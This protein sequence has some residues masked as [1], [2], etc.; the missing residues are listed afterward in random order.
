MNPVS[1]AKASEPRGTIPLMET[2]RAGER[3][4]HLASR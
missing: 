4:T 2:W 1:L 3:E